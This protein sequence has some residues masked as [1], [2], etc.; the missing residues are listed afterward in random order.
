[1]PKKLLFILLLV[2][3][4]LLAA[5]VGYI[6]YRLRQGEISREDAYKGGL[7]TQ[8]ENLALSPIEKFSN[9]QGAFYRIKGSFANELKLAEGRQDNALAGE[10]ILR[11]DTLKR[12]LPVLLGLGNGSFSLAT[13]D[14]SFDGQSTWVQV[15]TQDGT[16][17][18]IAGEEVLLMVEY[19]FPGVSQLPDY[20]FKEQDVFDSLS[21][22]IGLGKFS[23]NI[24]SDFVL[25]PTAVGIIKK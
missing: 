16:G 25:Y 13:Y 4:V 21:D 3:C 12:K 17:Q 15:K 6:V 11:G 10:F 2:S 7:I 22:D 18:L 5:T 24:P 20:F 8:K 1:M 19:L 14:G 23:Y 9:P